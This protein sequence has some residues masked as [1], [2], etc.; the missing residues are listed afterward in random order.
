LTD[1][2]CGLLFAAGRAKQRPLFLEAGVKRRAE[3]FGSACCKALPQQT[4]S[5]AGKEIGQTCHVERWNCACRQKNARHTR[6]TLSF[7]K[8]SF[9]HELATRLFI[10]RCYLNLRSINY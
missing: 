9:Y 8:T 7:S 6:K 3:C 1:A 5:I 2:G 4:H 10:V